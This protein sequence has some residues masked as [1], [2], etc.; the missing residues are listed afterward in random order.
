MTKLIFKAF[1]PL[2]TLLSL[3]PAFADETADGT[4]ADRFRLVE[5]QLR[6]N[7]QAI[8]KIDS[9]MIK[10]SAA[11]RQLRQAKRPV[12]GQGTCNDCGEIAKASCN[13]NPEVT[14]VE[15]CKNGSCEVTVEPSINVCL[16]IF[17][18][19]SCYQNALTA[20]QRAKIDRCFMVQ[21]EFGLS[22]LE[23]RVTQLRERKERLLD[24]QIALRAEHT[25]LFENLALNGELESGTK[26]CT[27]CDHGVVAAKQPV[28]TPD[29]AVADQ[30]DVPTDRVPASDSK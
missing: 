25:E 20:V 7:H 4:D 5:V 24:S 12:K 15:A 23:N 2:A 21:N 16:R 22:E 9:D 26:V 13:E 19:K 1:L 11:A 14:G 29:A 17:Q 18:N 10:A 6:S 8:A 28:K 3:A 30:A 27:N